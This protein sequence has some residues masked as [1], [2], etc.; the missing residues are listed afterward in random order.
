MVRNHQVTRSQVAEFLKCSRVS[1]AIQLPRLQLALANG[2]LTATGKAGVL[3]HTAALTWSSIPSMPSTLA[4]VLASW[5]TG[6]PCAASPE[7]ALVIPLGGLVWCTRRVLRSV[8]L[9]GLGSQRFGYSQSKRSSAEP[10]T[11]SHVDDHSASSAQE[12]HCA[13]SP[14]S[15]FLEGQTEVGGLGICGPFSCARA[16]PIE[17]ERVRSAIGC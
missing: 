6:C 12:A 17:W 7:P 3:R 5:A 4:C 2:C 11:V 9:S 10:G 8:V 14:S 13:T 1:L 16:T 15:L